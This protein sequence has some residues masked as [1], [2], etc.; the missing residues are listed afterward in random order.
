MKYLLLCLFLY[1][2]FGLSAQIKSNFKHISTGIKFGSDV[3]LIALKTKNNTANTANTANTKL[4]FGYTVMVDFVE[5][6]FNEHYGINLGVGFSNR[7]YQQ[8]IKSTDFPNI[9][10]SVTINENLLLQ[11]IEVPLTFRYYLPTK[12]INRQFYL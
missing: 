2:S 4:D 5:F 12:N 11:N 6:R 1:P 9:K 10:G 7:K 3:G 8:R